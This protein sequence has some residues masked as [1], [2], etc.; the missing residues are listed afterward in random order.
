[1]SK[2]LRLYAVYLLMLL[3]IGLGYLAILPLFEGFD[4]TANFSSMRQIADTGRIPVFGKDAIDREVTDYQ[5]PIP[6]GS[7]APPFDNGM[8]YSRFFQDQ[9]LVNSY[10]QSYRE[11]H[12]HAAYLPGDKPNYQAQH[13]PFYYLLMALPERLTDHLSFVTQILLLRLASYLLALGGVVFGLL[14]VRRSA[15]PTSALLGFFAYPIILP[16][17]FPE[18]ARMGNDSLCLLLIG[19][20]AYF[21]SCWLQDEGD[22]KF[23]LAIGLTL[24]LGM[25]TKA[26]FVPLAA[27]LL[28]FLLVRMVQRKTLS[29]WPMLLCMFVPAVLMGIAWFGHQM[30]TGGSGVSGE[31]SV[32][33]AE[34]GGLLA[35][36]RMHFSPFAAAR[37]LAATFV[38]W[39]WGGTWSLVHMS[40]ILLAPVLALVIWVAVAYLFELRKHALSDA[41]WLP[42]WLFIFFG[43]GLLYHVMIGVALVGAGTTP[44]W[45][46]HI[47]MPWTAPALGL[48]LTHIWQRHKMRYLLTGSLAYAVLF[49]ALALWSQFALF[50]GCAT[51]GIGKNYAFPDHSFCLVQ[52][53]L[54]I[55]RL[56]VLAWPS[57]AIAGFGCGLL[58][59][60]WLS[61]AMR[62]LKTQIGE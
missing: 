43:G 52:T 39:V 59:V 19:M 57:L 34:H 55:H 58:C 50:T 20:L 14:A 3:C 1:M 54:L 44:G 47:L 10:P 30:R 36:L 12:P 16:M 28:G 31:Q 11:S 29:R 32:A 46:L 27:A 26:F 6:Y 9:D 17:F 23:A 49:Q 37:G 5:G 24:G 22:R 33:L 2:Q 7:L 8:V 56:G 45:Y 38:T 35:G 21:L 41:A 61:L 4:E 25:L 53:P 62:G 18:F 40:P 60:L 15:A 48:G 51:K 42:V 13:P